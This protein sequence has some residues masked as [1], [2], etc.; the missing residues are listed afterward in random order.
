MKSCRKDY[1]HAFSLNRE[2]VNQVG[3]GFH[4]VQSSSGTPVIR[5]SDDQTVPSVSRVLASEKLGQVDI[6]D[7][8]F[9]GTE[10]AYCPPSVNWIGMGR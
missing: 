3:S 4:R 7:K 8:S 2:L 1:A 9:C 5:P 10:V 6:E